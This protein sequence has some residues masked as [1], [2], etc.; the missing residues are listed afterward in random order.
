MVSKSDFLK[1]ADPATAEPTVATI[2]TSKLAKLEPDDT[3]RTAAHLF[4][5]NRF[6]ALPV[7]EGDKL[8]GIIT[9]LDLIKFID[10]EVPKLEDYR[11]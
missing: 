7:L 4:A 2:M 1:L 10:R 8:V 5:L 11:K 6:H 9:T 3:L